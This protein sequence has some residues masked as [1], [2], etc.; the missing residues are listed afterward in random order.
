[1]VT[2]LYN[3]EQEISRTIASILTQTMTDFEWIVVDDGSTDQGTEQIKV[4]QDSRVSLIAQTNSGV[5]VARNRGI[6]KARAEWIAFL[7]ADDTWLPDFLETVLCLIHS[8]PSCMLVGTG[9]LLC[10][11]N[12]FKYKPLIKG[13]PSPVMWEGVLPNYFGIAAQFDPPFCSSSVAVQKKAILAIGGFPKGVH[14]GEDILT[15]ARLATQYDIAYSAKHLAHYYLPPHNAYRLTY[16]DT[17]Q[18]GDG[19]NSLLIKITGSQKI[20]LRR[21]IAKWHQIRASNFLSTGQPGAV[22]SILKAIRFGGQ[23]KRLLIYAIIACLPRSLSV[24]V[25]KNLRGI[26]LSCRKKD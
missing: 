19:L 9:Y 3:K 4:L 17:D 5:S 10:E 25:M 8:Y 24:I 21:Y 13:L 22:K 7:D 6:A 2:P 23:K 14:N 15:W 20:Y 16:L 26:T 18:V 1:M 11:K 12:G